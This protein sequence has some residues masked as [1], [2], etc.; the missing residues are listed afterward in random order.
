MSV[1]GFVGRLRNAT[2]R[3]PGPEKQK[4]RLAAALLSIGKTDF[5]CARLPGP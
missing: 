4:A 3:W 1:V 2:A 5:L